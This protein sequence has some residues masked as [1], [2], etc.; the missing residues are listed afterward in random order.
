MKISILCILFFSGVM[1]CGAPLKVGSKAPEIKVEKWLK[2]GPITLADGKGKNIY[3]VEFWATWCPPC[4]RSI[5]HL[6]KLQEKYK[7]KGL[8]VVGISKEALAVVE[9]FVK[10]QKEMNYNVGSDPKGDTYSAYMEG[11]GGIPNAFIINKDGLIVWSGH[12]FVVEKVLDKVMDGTFDLAKTQRI[13]ELQKK[14]QDAMQSKDI[15]AG[16]KVSQEILILK[17]DDNMAMDVMLYLFQHKNQIKEEI[18]FLDKLIKLHPSN[19]RPYMEKLHF[20]SRISDFNGV[21]ATA[22][23][24]IKQFSDDASSLN[25]LASILLELPFAAQPLKEALDAAEK[26]V[27]LTPASDKRYLAAHIDTLARCY[28]SIGRIGKAIEQEEKA[29]ALVQGNQGLGLFTKRLAFYREAQ[30]LGKSIK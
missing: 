12:P 24:Y 17:P 19:S 15:D 9:P 16:M 22:K 18:A 26:S 13:A 10:S 14:L 23:Q 11:I 27:A 6:S 1:L 29:L 30:E 3:V 4:R 7:D 28:Y 25:S 5:P 21:K 20:L 8:V 2:G